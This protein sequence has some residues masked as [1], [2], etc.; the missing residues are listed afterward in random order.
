MMFEWIN[1][2]YIDFIVIAIITTLQGADALNTSNETTNRTFQKKIK[3]AS[4]YRNRI[5]QS[6]FMTYGIPV[7]LHNHL[8]SILFDK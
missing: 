6:I 7:Y 4:K 5:F 3:I 1:L 2:S 8:T